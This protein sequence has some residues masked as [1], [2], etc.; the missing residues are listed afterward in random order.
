MDFF[1]RKQFCYGWVLT[2]ETLAGFVESSSPGGPPLE[3]PL[4]S[5]SSRFF[6]YRDVNNGEKPAMLNRNAKP[7]RIHFGT[8][9]YPSLGH[10]ALESQGFKS[11]QWC[12]EASLANMPSR[13]W[14]PKDSTSADSPF[15]HFEV[16][17]RKRWSKLRY[18]LEHIGEHATKSPENA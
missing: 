13:A 10:K 15:E 9:A 2:L 6:F 18:A 1:F 12:E 16:R 7:E 4:E 17:K 14:Q 5:A 3:S 11:K 8:V